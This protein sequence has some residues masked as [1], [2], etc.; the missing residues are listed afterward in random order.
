LARPGQV[1]YV[2]LG[3][4]PDETSF[5]RAIASS[6][7]TA[8]TAQKKA[9]ELRLR[10]EDVL[11]SRDI[12]LVVDESE[13]TLPQTPRAVTSPLRLQWLMSLANAG[14]PVALIAGENFSRLA[15]ALESRLSGFSFSQFWG[16]VGWR[17]RLPD[18]LCEED[19]FL[20]ARKAAPEADHPSHML[21]VGH[22]LGAKG[23]VAELESTVKRAR[24]IAQRAGR[25]LSFDDVEEAIADSKPAHVARRAPAPALTTA[26]SN[27]PQ[28]EAAPSM[29]PAIRPGDRLAVPQR[30][31]RRGA[32]APFPALTI[33]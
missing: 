18:S 25:P 19:L 20:I 13:Y 29:A 15:T 11:R 14:V 17:R 16:R 33:E 23:R 26:A 3:G 24:F 30:P 28:R 5:L 1:R 22:T 8:A 32:A 2:S 21:M 10:V 7:G 12:C 4:Y 27:F 6:L 9:I 31:L